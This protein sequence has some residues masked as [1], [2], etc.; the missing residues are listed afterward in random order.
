MLHRMPRQSGM[1]RLDIQLQVVLKFVLTQEIQ[2]SG[3]IR[4]ILM[5]GRFL[6]FRFDI[7]L[8][9]KSNLL[10]IGHRHVQKPG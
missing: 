2:A 8:A 6:G 1:V 10:L 3:R 5:L 9:L 7:E 4:V